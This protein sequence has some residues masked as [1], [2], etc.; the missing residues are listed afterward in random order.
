MTAY[1][2]IERFCELTKEEPVSTLSADLLLPDTVVYEAVSPFFGYYDDTPLSERN[3]ILYL[4]LE[5]CYS[6]NTVIRAVNNIRKRI[7]YSLTAD[8]GTIVISN[9]KIHIIRIKD[10]DKHCR[11]KHLQKCFID[12]GISLT[13]AFR[14][15]E[16]VMALIS[17]QK[18][19]SLI[20]VGDGLYLD[21]E[22]PN[23][24]YFEIPE[25]LS[26]DEFKD[27]TREAK[28]D[29]SIL[30]FDAAQAVLIEKGRVTDLVRI[31]REHLA[32]E[33]L[34]AIRDRYLKILRDKAIR[35]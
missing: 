30:Y 24:G 32:E 34:V 6:V 28:F 27:V 4:M 7:S 5:T 17:L 8:T 16:N 14:R 20:Q 35:K 18:F 33:K 3:S 19:Q 13:A 9:Q 22:D 15:V 12:E 1:S 26:W 29:T 10:I 2:I 11:I 23:K 31:Y 25:F 21:N